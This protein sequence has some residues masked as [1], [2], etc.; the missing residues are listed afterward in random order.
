MG[1]ARGAGAPAAEAARERWR[2]LSPRLDELLD[3]G[4][5][6]ARAARL[7]TLREQD[8]A[9]ADE[10]QALLHEQQAL[11]ERGFLER[12]ALPPPPAAA[13]EVRAGQSLGAY[14]L[15]RELG[16]GGMGQVW[17]ARRTDGRYDA[18]VAIKL[19][20]GGWLARGDSARFEREGSILAR[21]DH[22]HIARLLD[23][24]V[25]GGGALPY[26]VLEYVDGTPIDRHA[27]QHALPLRERVALM[28]DVADAVA[29]AHARGILHRDLK[30][31]NVLVSTAG[32]VKLLDFGIAKLLDDA[33]GDA[34]TQRAGVALTPRYAAPE[35]LQGRESTTATDVYALGVMLYGLLGG[36]HPTLP[37]DDERTTPLERLRAVVENEPRRLS[38]AAR[39]AGGADAARRAR[40][41]RGDLDTIVARTLLKDP[42]RRY[43]NAAELADELRRYLT[44][45][46]ILARPDAPAYRAAKFVRRN[47]VGVTAGAVAVAALLGGT[48]MALVQA[49]RAQQQRDQAEGLIEFMLGDLRRK[50]QPVGRLDALDAVGEKA[51]AYYAAQDE[52]GLDATSL[53]R[54]AKALHLIGEIAEQ[55]GQMAEAAQ[56]FAQAARSTAELLA[57]SPKDAQRIFDHAQSEFW[58]AALARRLGRAGEAEAGFRRYRELALQLVAIDPAKPAWQVELAAA[59]NNLGA[60]L[61]ENAQPAQAIEHHERARRI[62]ERDPARSLELGR[63]F[64]WI[65]R[66]RESLDDVDA[67]IAAHRARIDT[68]ERRRGD[69]NSE[70]LITLAQTDISRLRLAR[71]DAAAARQDVAPALVGLERLTARDPSNRDW[72]AALAFARIALA[73]A[74]HAEGRIGDALRELDAAHRVAA[75]LW[76]GEGKALFDVGLRARWL[77]ARAAVANPPPA[78]VDEMAAF[79]DAAERSEATGRRFSRLHQ[80]HLAAATLRLGD[81]FAAAG[82]AEA[83]RARWQRAGERLARLAAPDLPETA[84]RAHVA[85]RLGRHQEALTLADKLSAGSYRHPLVT[86][87]NMRMGRAP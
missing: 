6:A 74:V 75:P 51:L 69:A 52:A 29:H 47:H 60:W 49:H 17:L 41:L 62:Y 1:S 44:H 70:Y 55:R 23:A 78:L 24:G 45:Q 21:L 15:D 2:R 80:R 59:E 5:D 14:T 48:A 13:V 68:L 22:R 79:V 87:L 28:L 71:G 8:A 12:P 76:S 85:W 10:L 34:L 57:R 30:P 9:L 63:T 67:A 42:A 83:A 37:G 50:L 54:R 4:D 31:S 26:L 81:A 27:E 82:R 25:A 35:Q 38:D 61:F 43:A 84:L 18:Q 11:D 7:A 64:G 58:V 66:A 72:A 53:S 32:E 86:E 46:P 19:L 20:Q 39:R 40:E 16:R 77:A 36:G 73:E 65:A 33:G 3:L 56:R